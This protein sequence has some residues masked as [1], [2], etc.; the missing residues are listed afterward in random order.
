MKKATRFISLALAAAITFTSFEADVYAA[1]FYE[2]AQENNVSQESAEESSEESSE[3]SAEE[4]IIAEENEETEPATEDKEEIIEESAEEVKEEIKEEIN[5]AADEEEAFVREHTAEEEEFLSEEIEAEQKLLAAAGN[6][7]DINSQGVVTSSINYKYDANTATLTITGK[8]AIPDLNPFSE[9]LPGYVNAI[10]GKTVNIVIG[11]GITSIGKYNF[12]FADK[13][14]SVKLPNTLTKIGECAFLFE[15]FGSRVDIPASVT[16]IGKAAFAGANFDAGISFGTDSVVKNIP[17]NCFKASSISEIEFPASLTSIAAE[18]FY[19]CKN[20]KKVVFKGNMPSIGANAFAGVNALAYYPVD[21]K[22]YTQAK[23]NAASKQ[24]ESVTWYTGTSIAKS[25]KTGSLDWSY[26]EKTKT[27]TITGSGAMADYS[28][29]NKAPWY[30]LSIDVLNIGAGATR[31]GN[32]AFADMTIAKMSMPGTIKQ[33]GDYAFFNA[34]CGSSQNPDENFQLI[35]SKSYTQIGEGAF[36]NASFTTKSVSS[37]DLSNTTTIGS[38][39][40]SNCQIYLNKTVA[41]LSVKFSNDLRRIEDETFENASFMYGQLTLPANLTYVGEKAFYGDTNISGSLVLPDSVQE[42]DGYAFAKI[43]VTNVNVGNGIKN[44]MSYAFYSTSNLTD[45]T[46]GKNV[47]FIGAHAFHGKNY[48]VTVS[49]YGKVPN[50]GDNAFSGVNAIV[51]SEDESWDNYDINDLATVSTNKSIVFKSNVV[52]IT[53]KYY[54]DNNSS[55]NKQEVINYRKNRKFK[56]SDLPRSVEINGQNKSI[57]GWYFDSALKKKLNT[58]F[59]V[60]EA[61]SLYARISGDSSSELPGSLYDYI[62]DEMGFKSEADIPKGVWVYYK[63]TARYTGKPITDPYLRVF[64]HTIDLNEGKDYTIKYSNNVN[65]GKGKITLQFKGK[66]SGTKVYEFDILPENIAGRNYYVE[67]KNQG[68]NTI[69]LAYNGKVQKPKLE[70]RSQKDGNK[71]KLVENKDYTLKYIGTDKKD[72]ATYNKDAFKAVGTY[73]IAVVGKGNYTG[74]VQCLVKILN[75]IDINK[76]QISIPKETED[77]QE[78]LKYRGKDYVRY[79]GKPLEYGKDWTFTAEADY[80]VGYRTF[81]F[82]G[83]STGRCIGT[84]VKKVPLKGRKLSTAYVVLDSDLDPGDFIVKYPSGYSS[85]LNKCIKVYTDKNAAMKKDES[86]RLEYLRDYYIQIINVDKNGIT[87]KLKA[88]DY[89]DIPYIGTKNVEFKTKKYKDISKASV[90]VLPFTIINDQT[91]QIDIKVTCNGKTLKQ[92]TDY[93]YQIRE[94]HVS[95]SRNTFVNVIVKG[96]GTYYGEKT[97][98]ANPKKISLASAKVVKNAS[99]INTKNGLVIIFDDKGIEPTEGKLI[100]NPAFEIRYYTTDQTTGKTTY[101]KLDEYNDCFI[102]YTDNKKP[103]KAKMTIKGFNGWV[104]SKTLTY[105]INKY[106][107]DKIKPSTD[108]ASV[109]AKKSG[110]NM[111]TDLKLYDGTT[112]LKPGVDY[113]IDKTLYKDKDKKNQLRTNEVL[114]AGAKFYAVANFKGDYKAGQ[115]VCEVTVMDNTITGAK[116]TIANKVYSVKLANNKVTKADITLT[117]N[118]KP[119]PQDSYYILTTTDYTKAG[120][121]TVVI[122]GNS[123][124]GYTG[125]VK[126]TY[127][128]TPQKV[129]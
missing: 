118:G 14:K 7:Y 95:N 94:T 105:T 49:F 76:C 102:T 12:I 115:K 103:G 53:L 2:S 85:E 61:C 42:V 114:K 51:Y 20:L 74:T 48:P 4:Q 13:V 71:K 17:V 5:E 46:L 43:G 73:K 24:F 9:M 37:L 93:T 54:N 50:C 25:A 1:E 129:N 79:Q 86:K 38:S 27:L 40:F 98:A 19:G 44:I 107:I 22:T 97:V 77:Y 11:E 63:K 59:T 89:S 60:R 55:S 78:A 10:D 88:G 108:K 119:L 81:T 110:V 122:G 120:T 47:E 106:R 29:T 31:I 126:A 33:I 112:Y 67:Y 15:K 34:K 45:I 113:T 124:K 75:K 90:K 92:D 83:I 58:S 3:E 82:Q 32:Y 23:M 28:T 127:K 62:M 30:G 100:A 117:K 96:A 6:R 104:G 56:A 16:S 123:T 36:K 68:L 21:N 72:A 70:V 69:E 84:C 26:D 57:M 116:A 64:D 35:N 66:Y 111:P 109:L 65:A 39:A 41:Q 52:P 87:L 80:E 125:S 99:E 101:Q 128:I 8:G 121:V 91:G 18:A